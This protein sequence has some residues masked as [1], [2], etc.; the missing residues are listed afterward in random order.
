[1]P[2]QSICQTMTF[3]LLRWP[4]RFFVLSILTTSLLVPS[5]CQGAKKLGYLYIESS[6][7]NSSGGHTAVQFGEDIYHYQYVDPGIIRL[8]KQ[9]ANDFEFAY[10]F[11]NNRTI[12]ISPID[13]SD[14]T[15]SLLRDYFNFQ[16]LAQRQ[17]FALLTDLQKDRELLSRLLYK[18]NFDG[19]TPDLRLDGAGLFYSSQ[20]F[21]GVSLAGFLKHRKDPERPVAKI[22]QDLQIDIREKYGEDFLSRRKA[23]LVEQ[24]RQLQPVAPERRNAENLSL[25]RDSFP[26][27]VYS[28]ANH[29]TD[30]VTN[31]LALDALQNARPLVA[32]AYIQPVQQVFRLTP[33]EIETLCH[34]RKQLK[35]GL[36]QL[37]SSSRPDW[38]YAVLVNAARLITVDQ[39]IQQGQLVFVD[40][41]KQNS[42]WIDPRILEKFS[43]EIQSHS[44]LAL[45]ALIKVKDSLQ[46]ARDFN[47]FNY[48]RLELLSNRYVEFNKGIEQKAAIRFNGEFL[49]PTKSIPIPDLVYPELPKTV[50]QHALARVNAYETRMHEELDRLYAYNLFTRNCVTE[51]FMT[52]EQ[53]FVDRF[54]NKNTG[55]ASRLARAES[56][57]RLGGHVETAPVSFIPFTSFY[58]VQNN[59]KVGK[60]QELLSFRLLQ[61]Q[62]QYNKENDLLVFLR[63]SNTLSSTLYKRNPDDSFFVFFTDN[64]LLLR[65]VFGIFNIL[66]AT[67]Q[68][69]LGLAAAPFDSGEMLKSGTTG[70]V[71]SLPELAFFNMR[72]GS[73]HYLSFGW[74][75]NAE[76]SMS[77]L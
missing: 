44:E 31:L 77:K 53:A 65:P 68:S 67:G 2:Y 18:A 63:E 56:M 34:F 14:E 21:D 26:P 5:I 15:Y 1:M 20:E 30:L 7:G 57:Q 19:E 49:V 27:A 13:I 54:P 55:E 28:F 29:F 72:K 60:E 64:T 10:R 25:N 45:N 66:A 24:I 51:L 9:N 62:N 48:S 12:H 36:L 4:N 52:M 76:E 6:E 33:E 42:K 46:N 61:L 32:D 71:M 23:E 50:I 22:L 41:F 35:K 16:Y 59:Y 58:S 17:Q 74:Q 73:Y 47:E 75:M 11:L 70:V 3:Y 38:G 43:D 40:I 69:L 8:Q 37:L 39:S